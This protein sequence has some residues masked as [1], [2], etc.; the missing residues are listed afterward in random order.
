MLPPAVPSTS[1]P[2]ECRRQAGRPHVGRP[3][4]TALPAPGSSLST[5]ALR[6]GPLFPGWPVSG[7]QQ[8]KARTVSPPGLGIQE[9]REGAAGRPR[10]GQ[11]GEH[12]TRSLA[13][14]VWPQANPKPSLS[15]R[16]HLPSGL[17]I[18]TPPGSARGSSEGKQN[19]WAS[20]LLSPNGNQPGLAREDWVRSRASRTGPGLTLGS[21]GASLLGLTQ[22][23]WLSGPAMHI[24]DTQNLGKSGGRG[25]RNHCQMG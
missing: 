7:I 8:V 3:H 24:L 10:V 11:A 18:F 14:A 4:P 5:P 12:C 13:P 16:L 9:S 20:P 22:S 1:I 17:A 6:Q 25:F 19:I 2:G 15:L 21:P 23:A